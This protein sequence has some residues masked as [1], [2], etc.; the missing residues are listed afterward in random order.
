[1][2]KGRKMARN[3]LKGY[4]YQNYVFIFFLGQDGYGAQY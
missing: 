3:S 1:M 4:N 2:A